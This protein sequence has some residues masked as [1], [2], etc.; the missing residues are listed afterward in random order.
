MKI[1][2]FGGTGKTGQHFVRQAVEAGHT[3]VVLA[4]TPAKLAQ[5]GTRLQVVAGDAADPACVAQVVAGADVVVSVLGPAKGQAPFSISKAMEN[6]IH[7]MQA[8][9]ARRLLVSVGAGVGD[10]Q[11]QPKFINHVI[12]ALLKLTARGAYE[13][14]L[15]VATMVRASPLNWTLVRVPMLTD[16]PATGTIQVGAVGKGMGPRITRADMAAFI[17][18]QAA[19]DEYVGKAPAISN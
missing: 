7:A 14:M 17:L 4:R 12:N 6:I 2:V 19:S 18:G 3:V 1:A 16:D 15:K 5:A 8:A 10:P 11:D 9:G 13:D